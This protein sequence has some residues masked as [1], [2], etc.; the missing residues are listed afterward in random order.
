MAREYMQHSISEL[1]DLLRKNAQHHQALG[2]LRAELTLRS[3]KRAKQLLGEVEALIKGETLFATP[4]ITETV[5][6][7]LDLDRLL[8]RRLVVARFGEMDMAGWWNTKGQLGPLGATALRRGFPRTH[9][10]AQARSV[11]AVA[12]HRCVEIFDH[13]NAVTLWRLNEDIEQMFEARWEQWLD[14]ANEWVP[15]FSTVASLGNRSLLDSLGDLGLADDE[16]LRLCAK[17]RTSAES[18][19]VQLPKPF[20]GTEAD[21]GLL[22]LGFSLGSERTPVVPY[23]LRKGS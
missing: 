23:A 17:L 21:V 12:A 22:A 16:S 13:P 3:T 20:A 5:E 2:D 19:T 14:T 6:T 4:P 11:F 1:E 9:Y 15:F 18:R 7:T 8:Q 10:F